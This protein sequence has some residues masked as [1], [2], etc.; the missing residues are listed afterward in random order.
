MTQF[1]NAI[2]DAGS[3]VTTDTLA[4]AGHTAL[5]NNTQNEVRAISQKLGTGNSTPTDNQV[6]KG[7]GAGTSSWGQVDLENEVTGVLPVGS[8]GLGQ[9]SLSGLS[10]PNATLSEASLPGTPEITDFSQATHNHEDNTGGGTLGAGALQ[11]NA[12]T[13]AKIVDGAVTSEK[14]S[15]TIACKVYRNVAGNVTGGG[16]EDKL[17]LDGVSFDLGNNYLGS[18]DYKF[19][20]PITGYY[21]VNA[22]FAANNLDAAGA[23]VIIYIYVNGSAYAISKSYTGAVGN[24]PAVSVSDI[25]KANAGE[26]IEMYVD[27]TTTE[28][29]AVGANRTYMSI[30]FIGKE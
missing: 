21:Q 4:Q 10:L 22:C 20:A 8:G 11:S 13:T 9:N 27:C 26:A 3:A 29:I 30:Y 25:V 18:P 24:D 16:G 5:H 1:P 6:L 23:Q 12:V 7:T 15:A 19:V 14:L 17:N 2:P 28:A